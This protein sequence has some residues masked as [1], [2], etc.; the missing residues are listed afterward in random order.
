MGRPAH[1]NNREATSRPLAGRITG[2]ERV[3]WTAWGLRRHSAHPDDET[4]RPHH[5]LSASVST[6]AL[7]ALNHSPALELIP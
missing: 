2:D 5:I 1:K 3:G 6:D 4:L 7:I